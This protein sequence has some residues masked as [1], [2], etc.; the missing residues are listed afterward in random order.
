MIKWQVSFGEGFDVPFER[1]EYLV[2]V[3]MV[4]IESARSSVNPGSG[5][6][7]LHICTTPRCTGRPLWLGP[8]ARSSCIRSVVMGGRT[9]HTCAYD[10]IQL[11][12][13]EIDF[14]NHGRFS[15]FCNDETGYSIDVKGFCLLEF[16]PKVIT[17]NN[18]AVHAPM[19][20]AALSK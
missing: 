14:K 16:T 6:R 11:E 3:R 12:P 15:L 20:R 10:N 17:V 7:I 13:C 19:L 5:P 9:S 4:D 1:A 2:A 18:R 8:T